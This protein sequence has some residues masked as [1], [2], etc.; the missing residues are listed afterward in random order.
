MCPAEIPDM[1]HDKAPDVLVVCKARHEK[2]RAL[3]HE[4]QAWLKARGLLA[5]LY[6]AG[7]RAI[8]AAGAR[9]PRCV[10]V[11]GGDGTILGVARR[12]AFSGVPIFGINFGRVGFLTSDD[13]V[14]YTNLRDHETDSYLV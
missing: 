10:I 7:D 13:Y 11:L 2:A 14:S 12:F 5:R 4:V 9:L 3:G 1:P 6:E 8:G